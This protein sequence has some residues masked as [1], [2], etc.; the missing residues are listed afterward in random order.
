MVFL[1]NM[2]VHSSRELIGVF[3]SG[4]WLLKAGWGPLARLQFAVDA[5]IAGGAGDDKKVNPSILI[6]LVRR[7]RAAFAAA[8]H[9]AYANFLRKRL[10][11]EDN[12]TEPIFAED[13]DVSRSASSSDKWS[14]GKKGRA[15]EGAES[16]RAKSKSATK[17]ATKSNSDVRDSRYKSTLVGDEDEQRLMEETLKEVGKLEDRL[18]QV[19]KSRLGGMK[20]PPPNLGPLRRAPIGARELEEMERKVGLKPPR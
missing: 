11:D 15:N 12:E 2:C 17:R 4:P 19:R 5:G 20:T 14:V 18:G 7:S 3:F 10:Q 8:H 9:P 6:G 16:K 1:P 13:A